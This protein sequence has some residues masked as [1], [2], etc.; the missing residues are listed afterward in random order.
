MIDLFFNGPLELPKII[1]KLDTTNVGVGF[2]E[3]S[4]RI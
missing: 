1:D 3:Y 2:Q 4:A